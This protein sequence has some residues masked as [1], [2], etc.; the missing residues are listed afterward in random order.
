MTSWTIACQAPL[1]LGFSQEEELSRL[2]FPPPGDLPFPGIE[3]MSLAS[4]VLT[5]RFFTSE[6]LGKPSLASSL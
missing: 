1:S 6:P 5:G 3:P 2:P 4:L